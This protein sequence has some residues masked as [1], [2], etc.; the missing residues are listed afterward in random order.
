MG[1]ATFPG[2][3]F[4]SAIVATLA[5]RALG[6]DERLE[7]LAAGSERGTIALDEAGHGDPLE[8]VRVRATGRGSRHK[9][10][11]VKPIVMDGASADWVLVAART[12]EGLQ[13]FLVEP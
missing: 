3:F 1:R 8:R 9:L 6:L 13:S 10:D 7:A 4:S 2:P 12:R 5:A 11:G